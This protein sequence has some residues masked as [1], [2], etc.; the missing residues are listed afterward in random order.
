MNDEY[1]KIPEY[2]NYSI[3]KL[4][5]VRNDATGQIIT[6]KFNKGGYAEIRLSKEGIRKCIGVHRLLGILFIPNLENTNCIDHIDRDK[7]NNLLDNLRWA[8]KSENSR[9]IKKRENTWSKYKGVIWAEKRNGW[10]A[11]ITIEQKQISIGQFKTEDA[12]GQAY[13]KFI[14]EHKLEE[15]FILNVVPEI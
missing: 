10:R 12:A 13:N 11:N 5:V 14:I 1:F 8:T 3:T 9:N 4:G 15:F 6:P 7:K 2:E